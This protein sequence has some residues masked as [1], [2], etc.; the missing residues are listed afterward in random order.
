MPEEYNPTVSAYET[1]LGFTIDL[2][3]VDVTEQEMNSA[4]EELHSG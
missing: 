1:A 3:P 2:G 4:L